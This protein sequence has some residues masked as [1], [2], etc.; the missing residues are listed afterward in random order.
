MA[1]LVIEETPSNVHIYLK[2]SEI[3]CDTIPALMYKVQC[4]IEMHP[5]I[6][7]MPSIEVDHTE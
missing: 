5:G 2:Q 6:N 1:L 7:N 3:G 4:S